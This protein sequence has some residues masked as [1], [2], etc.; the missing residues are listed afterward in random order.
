M[1]KAVL[2]TK[3]NL[4]KYFKENLDKL[5]KNPHT[6]GGKKVP[7]T[8]TVYFFLLCMWSHLNGFLCLLYKNQQE[9]HSL[10][11]TLKKKK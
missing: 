2:N 5:K 11:K 3:E 8:L 10:I 9:M 6:I 1:S 7:T 4:D